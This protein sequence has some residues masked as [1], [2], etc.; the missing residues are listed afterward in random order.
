MSIINKSALLAALQPKKRAV[1]IDG[2]GTVYVRE[3]SIGEVLE[4]RQDADGKEVN[5]LRMVVRSVVDEAGATVFD[6]SDV[7]LL[8]GTGK[9]AFEQLMKVSSELNGFARGADAGN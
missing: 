2:F 1:E 6:E 3:L 8:K 9:T 5:P 7:E 4:I